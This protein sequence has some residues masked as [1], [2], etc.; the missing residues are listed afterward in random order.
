MKVCVGLEVELEEMMVVVVQAVYEAEVRS[1]N[2]H[3]NG[4]TTRPRRNVILC[5]DSSDG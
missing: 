5:W 3:V 4:N 1:I 2:M